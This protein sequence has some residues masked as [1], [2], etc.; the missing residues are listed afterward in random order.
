[1][2]WTKRKFALCLFFLCVGLVAM[3]QVKYYVALNGNDSN[4]GT[5]VRPFK[6]IRHAVNHSPG[7][8]DKNVTI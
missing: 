4:P 7:N 1:M 6:T 8:K 2:K 3:A 5:L